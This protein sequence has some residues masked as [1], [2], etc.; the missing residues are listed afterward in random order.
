MEIV[1]SVILPV[2]NAEKYLE[3]CISSIINQSHECFELIIVNDGSTDGS[4][5]IIRKYLNK[6]NVKYI[7]QDNQGVSRARN[8]AI[9]N[10]IGEY[11]IFVDADDK[12]PKDSLKNR[13][14]NIKNSDLVIGSY[15]IINEY[16]DE[17][18]KMSST[19]KNLIDNRDALRMLVAASE[20]GYQGYLWNKMFK[21]DI[22][23]KNNIFFEP[24]IFYG[25][26]RL[27]VA[28]YLIH[29]QTIRITD[30]KVY[31]YRINDN[32]AMAT[33]EKINDV[34]YNRLITEFEG[35]ERLKFLLSNFDNNLYELCL[36]AEI[37]SAL[38]MIKR[39]NRAAALIKKSCFQ[40][41][42]KNFVRYFKCKGENVP[43]KRKMKTIMRFIVMR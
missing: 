23:V 34:N 9:Q 31:E 14:R 10:A 25:E 13:I 19:G 12:L 28:E 11:L 21:R 15:S 20:I 27:F 22:I 5:N 33:F 16:E 7:K 37:E 41:V 4:E 3:K 2:Y 6:K 42:W 24:D 32:S 40:I 29:C 43:I 18:G 39:A 36:D 30:H 1:V 38:T 26:D 17:I 8:T 35:F